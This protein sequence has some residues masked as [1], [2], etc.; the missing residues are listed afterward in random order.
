MYT[1]TVAIPEDMEISG[2]G[3]LLKLKFEKPYS[4]FELTDQFKDLEGALLVALGY[5]REDI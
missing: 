1:F 4:L 5:A 3:N 2:Q